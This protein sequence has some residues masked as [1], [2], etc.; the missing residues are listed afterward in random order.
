MKK[1]TGTCDV[2]PESDPQLKSQ[3]NGRKIVRTETKQYEI[4]PIIKRNGDDYKSLQ[5]ANLGGTVQDI[6]KKNEKPA[7][8]VEPAT[9]R[10]QGGSSTVELRWQ[11]SCFIIHRS[12]SVKTFVAILKIRKYVPIFLPYFQ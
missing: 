12:A 8:G 7:E 10:L 11:L 2:N 1:T 9:T 3:L 5:T 6:T 4:G